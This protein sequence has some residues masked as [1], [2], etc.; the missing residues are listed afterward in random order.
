MSRETPQDQTRDAAAQA[1]AEQRRADLDVAAPVP[2]R[3]IGL[4]GKLLILTGI[5]VTLA[6]ILIFLPSIANFRTRLLDDRLSSARTAALVLEAAPSGMVPEALVRE[7]LNSAGAQAVALKTGPARRLLA[8][9]EQLPEIDV[10]VDMREMTLLSSIGDAFETLFAR[11]G[12][13]LR[14]MGTAPRAGDFVE[15]IMDETPLRRAMLRFSKTILL[16]SLFISGITAALVYLTLHLMFV[17]P[18]ARLTKTMIAFREN[19]EDLSRVMVPSGRKDEVGVAEYELQ[20]MQQSL[21]DML[22]QRSRLAALG[23]AVSKINH[24]LRNLLASAQLFSDR[25]ADVPDPTVQRFAP[26]MIQALD[27]A[28]AF[29]QSTLSYG[30]AHEAPPQ[31]SAVLLAVLADEVRDTM[32]LGLE[33]R[34]AFVNAVPDDLTVDADP[35]HL[36]RVLLN[37]GR[38]AQQ[39][40]EAR[41]PNDP[42]RD[43]IRVIGRREGAVAVIEISDTGPGIP[44]RA[45]A[46]L[47]EA[48]QGSTR[49]GGT[50][51]G[52]AIAS[53]LVR[54]HGGTITLAEGTLGATF[55]ISIPD[56]PIDLAAIRKTQRRRA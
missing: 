36:F 44:E 53:E 49:P 38:N 29:C 8:V 9:S 37:I 15:I 13:T 18:M 4:S 11:N 48:F 35:D 17:R 16:L 23:L 22:A 28:I 12:R 39:A 34:I 54:T 47:F 14:V 56:R 50:G 1:L 24:D 27:R 20:T 43:Q 52:L 25:L 26:K 19:P 42:V 5:F 33:A 7:L 6:E 10:T 51:L 45:R 41:A 30:R 55:Q 3:G 40:L 46:H 2:S 32:G 31:R 21:H